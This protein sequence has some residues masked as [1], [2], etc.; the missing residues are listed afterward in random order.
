MAASTVQNPQAPAESK[1]AKKKKAK[2]E[3]TESPV[4]AAILTPDKP[5]SG[6]GADEEDDSPYVRELRK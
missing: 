4:P 6:G 5:A 1:S 2:A 3:R